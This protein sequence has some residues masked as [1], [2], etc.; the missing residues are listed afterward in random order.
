[1]S[2]VNGTSGMNGTNSVNGMNGQ[3]IRLE[4]RD[5]II[6]VARREWST[7]I[8][9]KAYRISLAV[10]VLAV[11]AT[12]VIF[13][14]VHTGGPSTQKVGLLRQDASLA[15]PLEAAGTASG[16]HV[17]TRTVSDQATGQ[18]Q[19]RDGQLNALVVSGPQGLQVTVN[20]SLDGTLRGVLG[21]VARERALDTQIAQLGGD[22]GQVVKAAGSATVQVST[23]Q[24]PK[25]A[26]TQHLIVGIVAGFLIY[27]SLMT[28]GPMIAQGV[29]EE[30]SSRVVE[31][32]LATLR[33]WQLMAGKVLGIGLL[34]LVQVAV[35]GGAGV[36]A[37]KLTG[38]LSLSLGGSASAVLWAVV[39]YLAGFALYANLFAAS[40]ALVSRQEDLAGVQFPLI[41]PIMASW[42][43]GIS[44]LP[45]NPDNGLLAVLSMVPLFAPVLMPMRIALG[46]TPVWQSLTA[47]LL[48]LV[49]AVLLIRFA[50]RIYRNSVLRS[51]A[52]VGWREALKAA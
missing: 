45:G 6:L 1:M 15:A 28:C 38:T 13:H 51:G 9:A 35:V 52:R 18:A 34:G 48:T 4:S 7:R 43:I 46:V 44:V 26:R 14:F 12:S 3:D 25:P 21:A 36:A 24:P 5:A 27:L 50:A 42:I 41:M 29:V 30:K 20:K 10:M 49:L 33:P 22:P 19:V 40:G 8:R 17:V 23:L 32:L 47:L 2:G 16:Q 31:L 37:G 39:W 11:V